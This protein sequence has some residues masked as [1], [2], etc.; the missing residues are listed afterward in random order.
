MISWLSASDRP[1]SFLIIRLSSLGD[2]LLATP[3]LRGLRRTFPGAPIDV[4]VKER[5]A[6][7][8]ERNPNISSLITLKEPAGWADLPKLISRLRNRYQIVVDLHTSLRSFYL[9]RGIKA[10]RTLKYNKRRLARW[11]LIK[12]KRNIYG[13]DFSVPLAYLEA[14]APLGVRDDGGGLDWPEALDRQ[15]QFLQTASLGAASNPKP[16]A[17]CPGAS[18]PTKRWPVEYWQ[19]LVEKLLKTERILWVFGDQSDR[20]TGERLRRADPG[21][22]TNFCGSLSLAEAGAGLS[23]CRAAVTH[24]AGPAHMAAAVGVPVLAIFGSTVTQ[25]GFRPFRVPHRIAEVELPCRPCSHLGYPQ[26]PLK[27]HRCI[28]DLSADRVLSLLE[29]LEKETSQRQPQ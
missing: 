4:L 22:I 10:N 15:A 24:D 12:T 2:I 9:R 21:R 1:A 26:C 7:L 13:A 23:L 8:L 28:K 3:A 5:Y 6:E 25:F 19:E 27:H 16:I 17:L 11:M 29:N 14:L 18:F 20:D